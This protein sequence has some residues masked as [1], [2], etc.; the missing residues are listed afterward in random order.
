M[1]SNSYDSAGPS[2]QHLPSSAP[3][4]SLSDSSGLVPRLNWGGRLAW[5]VVFG[6][7]MLIILLTALERTHRNEIIDHTPPEASSFELSQNVFQGKVL[8]AQHRR[9]PHEA[10]QPE[11]ERPKVTVPDDLDEGKLLQ[12][13]CYTILLSELNAPEGALQH[14]EV[15]RERL[16]E[17]GLT[18][19]ENQRKLE[20][21]L[22]RIFREQV[23]DTFSLE[24]VSQSDQALLKEKFKWF[25]DLLLSSAENQPELRRQVLADAN[26]SVI[27]SAIV[28]I[29][30]AI[31]LF[32]SLPILGGGLILLY[33]LKAAPRYVNRPERHN[34]YIQ[35]FAIWMVIF[36]G[37]QLLLKL[38]IDSLQVTS[39]SQLFSFAMVPFFGS[40]IALA[41]PVFQGVPFSEVRRDIGWT[42]RNP[43][44]EVGLG[45][46]CYWMMLPLL[47][48]A[49]LS[50]IAQ[51]K[52]IDPPSP[53][54]F[55][56]SNKISHPIQE[57]VVQGGW[58]TFLLVLA[59]ACIAAPIVEETMFRGV[60]Y[61][62]LRDWSC[63]RARIL[64]V[65]FASLI[66]GLIFAAI[67]P[68]GWM[69]I[70]LLT[71][72]AIGFSIARE[73]RDS[74]I[75]P[76]IMHGINNLIVMMAIFVLFS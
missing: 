23:G 29:G 58:G 61:R 14:L 21:L 64:S 36:F 60:L 55:T 27:K 17:A 65:A 28:A 32:L 38:L 74:L 5:L 7:T 31:M 35:T 72:L 22:E 34:L 39:Q 30:S 45:P 66:N 33:A 71:S 56:N 40:L 51:T 70:P 15:T 43:F 62:H 47:F 46:L 76:M 6:L 13:W 20:A 67:H 12:R 57:I 25:G 42:A 18:P 37:G 50:V 2:N 63:G 1:S 68:Q 8:V 49:V 54:D 69:A 16:R 19:N 26:K 73:L 24:N 59:T 53:L 75:V 44:V 48:V 52:L 41:W 10:N 3:A 9:I 11:A 4:G